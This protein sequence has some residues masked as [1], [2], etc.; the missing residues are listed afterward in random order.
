M[1]YTLTVAASLMLLGLTPQAI[2]IGSMFYLYNYEK[3]YDSDI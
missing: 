1:K 3:D 2:I